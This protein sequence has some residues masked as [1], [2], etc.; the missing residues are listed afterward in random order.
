MT[1]YAKHSAPQRYRRMMASTQ[2]TPQLK[3]EATVFVVDDDA[4]VRE[5]FVVPAAV[6]GSARVGTRESRRR[7]TTRA[8]T[9]SSRTPSKE[10]RSRARKLI[11]GFSQSLR[12][13]PASRRA[14]A[15]LLAA[16]GEKKPPSASCAATSFKRPRTVPERNLSNAI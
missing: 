14:I 10:N 2:R 5:S 8:R 9:G 11:V 15:I 7:H 3:S 12:L 4:S 16:P 6:H 13:A 1:V